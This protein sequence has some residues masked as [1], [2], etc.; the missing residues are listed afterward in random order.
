MGHS[1]IVVIYTGRKTEV[2][3]E[4]PV[5]NCH[6]SVAIRPL[7]GQKWSK[8]VDN[9]DNSGKKGMQI[10]LKAKQNDSKKVQTDI[11]FPSTYP[12]RILRG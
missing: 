10:A 7:S 2:L 5:E 3:S 9:S 1:K 12:S 11:P 4:K 8:A 6:P